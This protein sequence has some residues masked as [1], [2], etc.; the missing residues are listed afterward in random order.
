MDLLPTAFRTRQ[1]TVSGDSPHAT[2][3]PSVTTPA[4][5][6]EQ[7]CQ[8][9]A[10]RMSGD[11]DAFLYRFL[12]R[13]REHRIRPDRR[14]AIA[15]D[16]RF[17]GSA[18]ESPIPSDAWIRC[19]TRS[20]PAPVSG[21]PSW[22]AATARSTRSRSCS[23]GWPAAGPERSL[24]LTGLRGV[25]KTVLLGELRSMA[26]RA[27][28]GAGKI[29]ARPEA[30]LRRPLSAAL[31]RAI[32]D[33]AVRHR[34]AGPRRRGA[35]RAQGVR[36][37]L[38]A[39][40]APS[41]ATAGSPGID[42]AAAQR[43]G[44]LRRH[45]DRPRR[46]VHRGRR[47]GRGRRHRASRILI[48]E[49]QDLRPD[50]VSALCAACHEL[51]QS[52]APLVVVGAGLPHL[53]AVLSASK[54]YSERLFRYVRIG[55]LDRAD[56]DF[57][58]LAPAEREDATFDADALDALFDGLRRLPLLRAGLRQGRLGRRAAQPDRRRRRQD[59][60]AGGRGGAGRR[61]LRVALRAGHPGRA[62]VPAGDGRADRGPRRAG[63]H[64]G[65]RRPPGRGAPRR[66]RRPATAC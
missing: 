27:G 46:A 41:C 44:R 58:L 22:P 39:G 49:M 1:R 59:G 16:S 61:L 63:G 34:D 18:Q 52:R 23:S 5:P 8:G 55:Q 3:W 24:V 65:H 38:R 57:A 7:P 4:W 56:A 30:D 32:R 31:H 43:P 50:D 14:H 21:R 11:V 13:R 62:R 28:W 17:Y 10:A 36:A 66:S 40:R 9:H 19:A 25:G 6:F 51:S 60:R 20:P 33:L 2:A 15:F 48:D 26:M 45:R 47:A 64:L 54:S 35:R 37:A 12:A 42:V 53:P 29:E